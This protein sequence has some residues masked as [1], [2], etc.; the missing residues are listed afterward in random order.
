MRSVSHGTPARS[1]GW[2]C[3]QRMGGAGHGGG[4]RG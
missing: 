1:G 3:G 2:G 4:H